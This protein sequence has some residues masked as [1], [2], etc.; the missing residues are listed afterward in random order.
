MVKGVNKTVI[1]VNDTGSKVFDRIVFYVSPTCGG[2]SSKSLNR[3]IKNFTF[4]IDE[5]AGRGYT[6]LRQR[7]LTRRRITIASIASAIVAT[8]IIAIVLIL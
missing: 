7:H 5:R 3:A 2:L 6:S 4:Q 8:A 1:E